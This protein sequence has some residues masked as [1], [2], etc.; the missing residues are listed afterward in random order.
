MSLSYDM[1]LVL[2]PI[3]LFVNVTILL[4][5]IL[6]M[7]KHY[8]L[9]REIG[10]VNNKWTLRMIKITAVISMIVSPLLFVTT[11]YSDP[12]TILVL[13][14][15]I[16]YLTTLVLDMLVSLAWLRKSEVTDFTVFSTPSQIVLIGFSLVLLAKIISC[17]AVVL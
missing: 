7:S 17:C 4:F 1:G 6:Q 9:Y 16:I 2:N 13:M 14:L 12:R 10:H 5:L 8:T 15:W 3:G 11:L